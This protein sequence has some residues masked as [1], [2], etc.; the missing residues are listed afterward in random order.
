MSKPIG[1]IDH[2]LDRGRRVIKWAMVV[3]IFLA[4]SKGIV[5]Y[6]SGSVGLFA[7]AIDSFTDLIAGSTVYLGL[8]LAQR[9]PSQKYPYGYFKAETMAAL[10]VAIFIFGT[11]LL[12]LWQAIMHILL[13]IEIAFYDAALIVA[14]VSIPIIIVQSWYLKKIGR[15]TGSEAVYSI[16]QDYRMDLYASL[17]VLVGLL[18]EGV[19]I[20][21]A[22]AVV[23][24]IIGLVILKSS[25]EISYSSLLI[26]M[27]AVTKPDQVKEITKLASQVR[28]VQ[29]VHDIKI[30]QA[31]PICFGEAHLEVS[32]DLTLSQAH[33]VSDEIEMRVAATYPEMLTFLVHLEPT[34]LE[35][36]RIAIPVDKAG[37]TP[38]SLPNSSFEASPYFLIMDVKNSELFH[39]RTMKNP[40]PSQKEQYGTNS[41]K[42]L[43]DINVNALLAGEIG[44]TPFR[45]LRN[46]LVDIHCLNLEQ[47]CLDNV[48][49]FLDEQLPHLIATPKDDEAKNITDDDP[50][51]DV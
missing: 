47:T 22:E 4:L 36:F 12:V 9:P 8:W 34:R 40:G 5:G 49:A 25:L 48:S 44:E 45:I 16:G 51:T 46:A 28:G 10:V 6:F 24:F 19:G 23:G 31:G 11:G 30:R 32:A 18:F 26:L 50:I 29:G 39:W 38:E 21:W 37:S 35:S 13:P 1:V 3:V 14:L 33:R 2:Q 15:E 42:A 7:Q 27:D 17:V 43:L 41:A 20:W